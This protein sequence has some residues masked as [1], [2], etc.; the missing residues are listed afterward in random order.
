MKY[1]LNERF[2]NVDIHRDKIS[3]EII[4]TLFYNMGPNMT[5]DGYVETL[6]RELKR[7]T[8]VYLF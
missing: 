2:V 7:Y 3:F 1:S 6:S 4:K 5:S 8:I